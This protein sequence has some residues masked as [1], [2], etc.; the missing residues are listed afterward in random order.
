MGWGVGRAPVD[1]GYGVDSG[2]VEWEEVGSGRWVEVWSSGVGGCRM[3]GCGER[4]RGEVVCPYTDH[5]SSSSHHWE[6][7]QPVSRGRVIR[8]S[9]TT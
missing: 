8:G 7:V 3:C 6:G 1:V 4:G 2:E 9:I 5:L